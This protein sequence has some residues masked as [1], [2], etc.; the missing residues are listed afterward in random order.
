VGY[1]IT[2]PFHA[3]LI[4][5]CKDTDIFGKNHIF[6]Q[7]LCVGLLVFRKNIDDDGGTHNGC[8]GVQ[9]DDALFA[10]QEADDIAKKCN[11]G[12][13]EDGAGHQD[14]VVGHPEQ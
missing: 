1:K 2:Y 5:C 4:N 14:A 8:D 3:L 12:A 10:G 13:A 6:L 11:D 9:G 7:K